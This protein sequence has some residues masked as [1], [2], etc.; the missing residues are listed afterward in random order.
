[1]EERRKVQRRHIMCYS[2][3]YDRRTGEV[4]GYLLDITPA[5]MMVM[6]DEPL[7]PGQRSMFRLDLPEYVFG[8]QYLNLTGECVWS[9][10]DIDPNFYTSGF[11][12]DPLPEE[13]VQIIEGLTKEFELPE[14]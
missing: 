13:D 3:I 8:K 12:L 10:P 11:R 2:R 1:M 9:R 7:E 14:R 6:G 4:V 5:G